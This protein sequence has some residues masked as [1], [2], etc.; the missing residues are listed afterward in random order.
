MCEVVNNTLQSN[1]YQQLLAFQITVNDFHSCPSLD[2]HCINCAFM[3][4]QVLALADW[5]IVGADEGS[6]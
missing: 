1:E 6:I 3:C 4:I 2:L 5:L